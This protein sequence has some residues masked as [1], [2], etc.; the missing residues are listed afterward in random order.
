MV[1]IV[2]ILMIFSNVTVMAGSSRQ[3]FAFA[4]DSGVPFSRWVAHVRPG[5]DVPFN[6]ILVV[7]TVAALLALI[8]I[9]STIGFNIITSLGTGT[10]TASYILTIGCVM[11]RKLAGRP[12]LPSRFDMGFVGGLIVNSLAMG[13]LWLVFI[14]AFFPGV[15]ASAG[16]TLI[17]MNWSV[18]VFGGVVFFALI[19]FAIWGRRSYDGPVEYVRKL[20]D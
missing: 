15:P 20:D 16:L 2:I 14:I 11:W 1:A 17:S 18:V 3:L 4:R 7:A 5:M 10:L 13:Y 8:N 6:A 12:L 9:G 19:Y